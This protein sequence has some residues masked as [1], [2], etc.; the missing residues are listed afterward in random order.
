MRAI[1][2]TAH[3]YLCVGRWW[4]WWFGCCCCCVVIVLNLVCGSLAAGAAA[5]H[6]HRPHRRVAP[7]RGAH[8]Y[9]AG[10]PGRKP[11]FVQF[12]KKVPGTSIGYLTLGDSHHLHTRFLRMLH[13]A[14]ARRTIASRRGHPK[15][16]PPFDPAAIRIFLAEVGG[17]A[18]GCAPRRV[19]ECHEVP[20]VLES[21]GAKFRFCT[22]LINPNVF[23]LK[24]YRTCTSYSWPR[25][26]FLH[27]DY[28]PKHFD[29]IEM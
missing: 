10:T 15:L 20:G 12:C 29:D 21:T 5:M 17:C 14:R 1:I 11:R 7:R 23:K 25:G 27:R 3:N 13:T 16:P 8:M 24:F 6:Q 4:W 22:V 28:L 19:R 9:R 2:F 26:V 18:G